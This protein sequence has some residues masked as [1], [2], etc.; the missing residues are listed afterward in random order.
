MKLTYSSKLN[1]QNLALFVPG[2]A[3]YVG[4]II[5]SMFLC[6]YYSFFD[7]DG[8]SSQMDFIGFTNYVWVLKNEAFRTSLKNTFFY[9]LFGTA[10]VNVISIC[11]A[12]LVN[13]KS[14]FSY[15][16]RAA[17]FFPQL[18]S[19]VA[20]GFIF[21][22]LLSYIGIV[23]SLFESW[24]WA[25][26]DFI[27]SPQYA[28]TTVLFISVWVSTGF[29]T[30]LYLAG[31]QAIPQNLYEAARL[32]GAGAWMQF[33]AVTFPWLAPSFTSVTVFLFTGYMKIY[34]VIFVMTNGGPAGRTESIAIQIMKIGFN[35]YRVSYASAIATYMMILVITLS[36]VLTTFLRKREDSLIS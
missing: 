35:Q 31:L 3:I 5:L 13:E 8:L 36:L 22:G 14:R 24:G 7:W 28:R 12:I 1:I 20:V 34:D 32:D 10:I 33:K 26:I 9:A 27:G 19:L 15:F 6:L 17:F 18:I 11:L 29:A 21:K 23:N 16:Y 2:F 30:V 25:K 4:I